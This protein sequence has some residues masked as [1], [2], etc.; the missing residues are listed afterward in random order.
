MFRMITD[1]QRTRG[2]QLFF[3]WSRIENCWSTKVWSQRLHWGAKSRKGEG[4]GGGHPLLQVGVQGSPPENFWKIAS[5]W[6]ILLHFE[7]VNANFKTENSFKNC[8]FIL[9]LVNKIFFFQIYSCIYIANAAQQYNDLNI[10]HCNTVHCTLISIMCRFYRSQMLIYQ[11]FSFQN[12]LSSLNFSLN[13]LTILP[14]S[15]SHI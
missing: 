11:T 8:V 4:G 7:A 10:D 3:L 12:R 6:C 13:I 1:K 2:V 15:D 14:H 9:N 5:K